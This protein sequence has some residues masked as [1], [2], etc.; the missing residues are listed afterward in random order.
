MEDE[1]H[2]Q[3]ITA[4]IKKHLKLPTQHAAFVDHIAGILLE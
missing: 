3:Q 2:L 1:N 4:N